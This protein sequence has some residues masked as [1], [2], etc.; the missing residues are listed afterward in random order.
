MEKLSVTQYADRV[1][2]TRQAVL[3]QIR[4]DRLPENVSATKIGTTY[5]LQITNSK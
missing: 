3:A 5:V 4:E 2:L 1:G